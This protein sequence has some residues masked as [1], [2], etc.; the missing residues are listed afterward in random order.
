VSRTASRQHVEAD[1]V[2][3]GA[4]NDGKQTNDGVI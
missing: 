1:G 2:G 3:A 4:S